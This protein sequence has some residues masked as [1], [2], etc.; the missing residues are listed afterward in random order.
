MI[1]NVDLSTVLMVGDN[2]DSDV[3][4]GMNAGIDTCWLNVDGKACPEGVEPTY[5][6]ASLSELKT[7]LKSL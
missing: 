7:I 6:V 5:E 4:G 3:L 2:P 1:G